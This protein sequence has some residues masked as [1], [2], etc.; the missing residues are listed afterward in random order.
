MT[1]KIIVV[2]FW[3]GTGHRCEVDINSDIYISTLEAL[4]DLAHKGIFKDMIDVKESFFDIF[5]GES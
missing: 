4:S 1:T 2:F 5:Y 3:D